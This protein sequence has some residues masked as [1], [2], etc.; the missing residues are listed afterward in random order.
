ML[1]LCIYDKKNSMDEIQNAF[2]LML[3]IGRSLWLYLTLTES[4]TVEIPTLKKP[5]LNWETLEKT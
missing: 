1:L 3:D 4:D 5:R 2:I